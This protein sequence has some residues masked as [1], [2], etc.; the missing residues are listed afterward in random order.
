MPRRRPSQLRSPVDAHD[1][2]RSARAMQHTKHP[3]LPGSTQAAIRRYERWPGEVYYTL[4][5]WEQLA[6]RRQFWYFFADGQCVP[7]CCGASAFERES[8]ERAICALPPKSARDLRRLVRG[9]DERILARRI[10]PNH[11]T[12]GWWRTA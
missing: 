3:R 8:L 4:S 7:E 1:A 2:Y 12:D 5:L 9:L 6:E 10:G 11:W